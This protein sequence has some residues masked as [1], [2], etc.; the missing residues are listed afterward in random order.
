MATLRLLDLRLMVGTIFDAGEVGARV[1][2]ALEDFKSGGKVR[3]RVEEDMT[4]VHREPRRLPLVGVD[5]DRGRAAPPETMGDA[6]TCTCFCV[7]IDNGW[8]KSNGE[9]SAF[10]D[11]SV[12]N[13]KQKNEQRGR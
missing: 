2:D 7:S 5:D 11:M 1:L 4:R 13:S 9:Q 3:L 8:R 10:L 6:V 12:E